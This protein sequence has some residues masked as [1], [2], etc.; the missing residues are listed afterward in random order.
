MKHFTV[1]FASLVTVLL[2]LP[3]NISAQSSD[4]IVK[5][6]TPSGPIVR[7]L[8]G[9]TVEGADK[10]L[11]IDLYINFEFD[12]DQ[13]TGEGQMTLKRLGVA[14]KDPK[15]SNYR[16]KIAGHT[17][18]TGSIEYNQNLSE[19]RAAVVR[20]VLLNQFGIAPNRIESVGYGKMQLLDA[21]KPNDG[22]NRRVQVINLGN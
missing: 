7:S 14:L 10:P 3:S 16:F 2:L 6:L 4:E 13:L 1:F 22:I 9:I 15:L 21:S 18:A 5:K 19:R 8:R 12:S 11:S 17:D 20:A